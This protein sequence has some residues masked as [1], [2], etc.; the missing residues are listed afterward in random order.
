MLI[1]NDELSSSAAVLHASLNVDSRLEAVLC[2]KAL[3]VFVIVEFAVAECPAVASAMTLPP[4]K[5][6][7]AT[8]CMNSGARCARRG[9]TIS[10]SIAE[11][12]REEFEEFAGSMAI[13]GCYQSGVFARGVV[14]YR[15]V[16]GDGMRFGDMAL[17]IRSRLMGV[18]SL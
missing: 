12:S 1:N 6:L 11:G 7:P 5:M 2:T 8:L 13:C 9:K 4:L 14:Y 16:R 15:S 10:R 17:L 18:R 3:L